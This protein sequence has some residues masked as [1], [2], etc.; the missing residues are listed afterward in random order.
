MPISTTLVICSWPLEIVPL[1][2]EIVLFFWSQSFSIRL[3]RYREIQSFI[4]WHK[5]VVSLCE[6]G[7]RMDWLCIEFSWWIIYKS[8]CRIIQMNYNS[9]E[10]QSCSERWIAIFSDIL[11]FD[12]DRDVRCEM[13]ERNWIFVDLELVQVKIG[14]HEI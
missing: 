1:L 13:W 9:G 10:S 12:L 6:P 14:S 8:S 5:I 2:L 3:Y 11:L 4:P 7:R